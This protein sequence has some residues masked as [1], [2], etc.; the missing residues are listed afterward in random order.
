MCKS[1]LEGNRYSQE[2]GSKLK[3]NNCKPEGIIVQSGDKKKK[4][5]W[6]NLFTEN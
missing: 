4:N 3:V 5:K 1:I 6:K 2:K